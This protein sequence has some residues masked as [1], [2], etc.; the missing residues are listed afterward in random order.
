MKHQNNHILEGSLT[1]GVISLSTPIIFTMFFQS[2][3]NITDAFW[4]GKVGAEALAAVSVSWPIIFI[5][6]ALASGLSIGANALVARYYGAGDLKTASLVAENSVILG[7][8]FSVLITIVGLVISPSLFIY[9]G[10]T[11]V[12]FDFALQYTNVLFWSSALMFISFILS[13]ILRGEGDTKT[14][15]KIGIAVNIVNFILDPIFIFSLGWSVQGAAVATA[16]ANLVGL[17]VYVVFFSSHPWLNNIIEFRNFRPNFEFMK[18]IFVI[19]W[20]ASLRNISN[21]IGVFF[22]AKIIAVYG[23]SVLAAYGISFRVQSFGVLPVVAIATGTIT[24]VGQNLGAKQLSRAKTS[25][26]VSTA[27]GSA[28]MA[29][30]GLLVF[31]FADHIIGI[32][33]N[34]PA[35]LAVG[36]QVMKI[37]SLGFIFSAI[38]MVLSAA[39]QAFGKSMYSF[40]VTAVRVAVMVALAYWWNSLWGYVGVWWAIVASGL[41]AAVGLMIWYIIYQPQPAG[42]KL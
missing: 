10:V 20:P 40:V 6:I 23:A 33:N 41:I 8:G 32:F 1:K 3:L 17:A 29:V 37:E 24:I 26:W 31:I 34:E 15:M 7:A 28:I 19:G 38:I 42:K 4:L 22:T 11:G 39:F 2:L 16:L 36:S 21:A 25:G 35:V 27:I 14:P 5:V 30:F 18:E 13:S 12:V 9:M